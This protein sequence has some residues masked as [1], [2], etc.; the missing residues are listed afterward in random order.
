L[1]YTAGDEISV[2]LAGGN[3]PLPENGWVGVKLFDEKGVELGH[4]KTEFPAT[5]TTRAYAGMTTLYVAWIGHEYDAAGAKYGTPMGDTFGVGMRDSFLAGVHLQERHIEEIVTTNAFT[6]S[7][8]P[9]SLSNSNATIE[10]EKGSAPSSGGGS[11][12]PLWL[13]GAIGI[14]LRTV[15]RRMRP[16]KT[17]N[18]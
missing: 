5:L 17:F 10:G 12:D 13:L 2:T 9:Q 11:F 3:Q 8:T 18:V 7:T 15:R 4:S 6:V 14:G 16:N 1:D